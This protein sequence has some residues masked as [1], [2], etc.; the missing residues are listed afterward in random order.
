MIDE[1]ADKYSV[2]TEALFDII[3]D[4]IFENLD[5]DE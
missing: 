1:Y 4:A 2:D 3:E 5:N